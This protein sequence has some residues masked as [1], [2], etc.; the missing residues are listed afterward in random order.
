[1]SARQYYI[2]LT[3]ICASILLTPE[4]EQL[5][6]VYLI[7]VVAIVSGFISLLFRWKQLRIY[8]TKRIIA[9][10]MEELFTQKSLQDF[11]KIRERVNERL[12][13][14]E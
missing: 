8:I 2:G 3:M 7:T 6:R 11:Q 4:F 14:N 9:D 13:A 12:K 10:V 1:M 5:V